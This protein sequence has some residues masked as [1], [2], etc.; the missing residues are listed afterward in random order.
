MLGPIARIL[1]IFKFP[2][3]SILSFFLG[4]FRFLYPRY[5]ITSLYVFN[6]DTVACSLFQGLGYA[7][8]VAPQSFKAVLSQPSS[9]I[10]QDL[11]P[12]MGEKR[13]LED[14]G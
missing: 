3:Y 8:C 2:H 5:M 14:H 11:E 6:F 9:R 13:I 1:I 12:L 10:L 7:P 4:Q